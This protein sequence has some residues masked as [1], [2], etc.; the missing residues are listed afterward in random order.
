MNTYLVTELP[1]ENEEQET[2]GVHAAGE[3]R[4]R[5]AVAD[6]ATLQPRRVAAPQADGFPPARARIAR[7]PLRQA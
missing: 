6:R 7:I 1:L 3:L 5:V 2:N 4:R